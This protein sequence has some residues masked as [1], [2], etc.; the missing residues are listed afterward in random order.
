M[1][2]K[3]RN[4]ISRWFV[5]AFGAMALGVF[6]SLLMGSI[7]GQIGKWT[8]IG[9]FTTIAGYAQESHV[10]GAAIGVA[11]ANGLKVKPLVMLSGAVCG[12]IGYCSGGGPIGAYL[13]SLVGSELSNLV[14]GKTHF[15]IL[16]V[17]GISIL[18]GGTVGVFVGPYVQKFCNWIGQ[19]LCVAMGLQPISVPENGIAPV[20]TEHTKVQKATAPE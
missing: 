3:R 14:A 12:T 7:L 10:V 4:I 13:A 8:N 1:T 6:A 18:S 11:V 5:D 2:E 19:Q 15:D 9:F 16:L 17:P 20:Q